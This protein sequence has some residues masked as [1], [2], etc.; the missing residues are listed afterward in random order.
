MIILA[1]NVT[2]FCPCP[3]N[4]SEVKL[5]SFRLMSMTEEILR[6]SSTDCVMWLLMVI[7]LQ[8]YK[9]K[10]QVGHKEIQC[11]I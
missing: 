4:L 9:E 10:E 2:V 1:K 11:T 8:T 5:Q 3:N 7:L 6:Q